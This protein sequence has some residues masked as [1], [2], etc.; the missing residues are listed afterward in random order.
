MTEFI[1]QGLNWI[2]V[3]VS[4]GVPFLT[5]ALMFCVVLVKL[6]HT[7]H[8]LSEYSLSSD[9]E[10]IPSVKNILS[11]ASESGK[12]LTVYVMYVDDV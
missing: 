4:R 5:Q 10:P 11:N 6:F 7:L 12:W 2:W 3:E 1:R 9:G 8:L